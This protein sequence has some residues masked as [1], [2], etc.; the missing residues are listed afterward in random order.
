M[1]MLVALF[2]AVVAIATALAALAV[3]APRAVAAKAAAI[4]FAALLM[5]AGYVG[6]VELLG[7][8]KPAAMEWFAG[9]TKEARVLAMRFKEGEAIYLWLELDGETRPRAYMLP[10]SVERA[11][12]LQEAMQEAQARGTGVRMRRPFAGRRGRQ[13]P[14][15]YAA[16]RPPLPPKVPEKGT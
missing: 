4:G 2:G 13:D 8:P 9:R 6:F 5:A 16:P 7:R 12:E 1:D 11:R 3:W 10:W 15:F 14:M